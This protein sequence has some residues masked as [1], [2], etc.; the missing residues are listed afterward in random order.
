[1]NIPFPIRSGSAFTRKYIIIQPRVLQAHTCQI[2]ACSGV[3]LQSVF[4]PSSVRTVPFIR[5]MNTAR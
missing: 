3:K 4:G 2:R 1:M 5:M